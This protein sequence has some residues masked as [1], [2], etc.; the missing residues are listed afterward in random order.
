LYLKITIPLAMEVEIRSLR[1]NANYTISPR[2]SITYDYSTSPDPGAWTSTG[3]SEDL[4]ITIKGGARSAYG[5]YIQRKTEGIEKETYTTGGGF[6]P[7]H[8]ATNNSSTFAA[9]RGLNLK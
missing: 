3:K 4:N 7:L 2:Q 9:D 1:G 6:S 5:N 8:L